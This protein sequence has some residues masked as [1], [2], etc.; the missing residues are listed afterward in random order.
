MFYHAL[1][2]E[3]SCELGPNTRLDRSTNPPRIEQLHVVF[4]G[5]LGACIV[6]TFPSFL[7]SEGARDAILAAGLSGCS[8]GDAEVTIG[9]PFDES[10]E[11]ALLPRFV[12]LQ[13]QGR[14]GAD[15]FGLGE[16]LRLVVSTKALTCLERLGL[17]DGRLSKWPR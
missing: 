16:D 9:H 11:L 1:E 10:P 7:V 12:W 15:D 13:V 4:R 3:T 14:A 6:E 2:P 5:W 8:F 17:G